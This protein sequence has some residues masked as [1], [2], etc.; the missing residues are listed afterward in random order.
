LT[1]KVNGSLNGCEETF[2]VDEVFFF[3]LVCTW[4]VVIFFFYFYFFVLF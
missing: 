2:C 4:C 1:Y 3:L